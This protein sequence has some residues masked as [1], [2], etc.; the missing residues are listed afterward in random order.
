M[1]CLAGQLKYTNFSRSRPGS[2][3]LKEQAIRNDCVRIR[4]D[5]LRKKF[6]YINKLVM[7][8]LATDQVIQLSFA[9]LMITLLLIFDNKRR[10]CQL[11]TFP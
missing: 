3:L 4:R 1:I 5:R 10:L 11:A 6:K 8:M 9:Q 7:V 2:I